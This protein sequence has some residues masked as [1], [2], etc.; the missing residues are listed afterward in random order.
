MS[1]IDKSRKAANEQ[2]MPCPF[3]GE[4]AHIIQH[5]FITCGETYGVKCDSCNAQGYQFYR[6][7]GEA[8][9][10][11]NTRKEAAVDVKPVVR[12]GWVEIRNYPDGAREV[13]CN[14]CKR[15][16][17]LYYGKQPTNFCP[18]CGADMEV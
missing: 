16:L 10:A 17:V 7:M 14:N 1:D 6:T 15:R 18:N 12:G 13:E 9:A 8:V 5:V 2:L 4:R 3:C 11:W